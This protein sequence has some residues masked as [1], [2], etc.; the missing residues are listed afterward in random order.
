[1]TK[2]NG[3]TARRAFSILALIILVA[4]IALP[5]FAQRRRRPRLSRVTRPTQTRQLEPTYYTVPASTTLMSCGLIFVLRRA[6]P[7]D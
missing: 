4:G 1:M 5:S 6:S 2:V 3:K 7:V